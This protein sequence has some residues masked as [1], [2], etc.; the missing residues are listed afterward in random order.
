MANAIHWMSKAKQNIVSR[1]MTLNPSNT[2]LCIPHNVPLKQ[3]HARTTVRLSRGIA[4]SSPGFSRSLLRCELLGARRASIRLFLCKHEWWHVRAFWHGGS[5]LDPDRDIRNRLSPD[6]SGW[7]TQA[8]EKVHLRSVVC[9]TCLTCSRFAPAVYDCTIP[10]EAP[11]NP[12]TD[13]FDVNNILQPTPSDYQAVCSIPRI[14]R[15]YTYMSYRSQI[16]R[17]CR[18]QHNRCVAGMK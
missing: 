5:L 9:P 7:D 16:L 2:N 17:D 6:G 18:S 3:R 11:S 15:T 10:L 12:D 8:P 13:L 1:C 4:L 14:Y